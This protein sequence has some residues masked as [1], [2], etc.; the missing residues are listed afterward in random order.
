MASDFADIALPLYLRR[1]SLAVT[2]HWLNRAWRAPRRLPSLRAAFHGEDCTARMRRLIEKAFV[3]GRERGVRTVVTRGARYPLKPLFVSGAVSELDRRRREA[4]SP[5]ELLD[6]AN[7]FNYRGID[8]TSWQKKTEIVDLLRLVGRSKAE[9]ILEI[10]TASGGTL[11]ML[12]AVAPPGATIVSVDLPGG[13]LGG[14]SSAVRHRYP[15]WRARLYRGFAHDGKLLHVLRADSQQRSTVDS[16]SRVIPGGQLDFLFIDGDHSYGG[17][18]RDFE[19]YAP[20]V[21][22]GGLVAFHDIVPGGPGK[23]GDPGSVPVFWKELRESHRVE[24]EFVEDW[25]W[26]SCGIGVIRF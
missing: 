26:G 7:S 6:L 2:L 8:I 1:W 3:V 11:F 23:Q 10:G 17:V 19:L 15:R 22:R 4:S 18:S 24:A 5:E 16:V 13:R 20:L 14:E 21:R 25:E 9:R 12:T